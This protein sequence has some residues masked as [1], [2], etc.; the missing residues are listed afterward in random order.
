MCF[1][2]DLHWWLH[3]KM[4][5]NRYPFLWCW[6]LLEQRYVCIFIFHLKSGHPSTKLYNFTFL[7]VRVVTQH[8]KWWE[9]KKTKSCCVNRW[10][11][12]T[13]ALS[14]NKVS[15]FCKAA[16]DAVFVN[17]W[18]FVVGFSLSMFIYFYLQI[19]CN[20]DSIKSLRVTQTI[21]YELYLFSR[22]SMLILNCIEQCWPPSSLL[23][24]STWWW[25]LVQN[26]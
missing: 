17:A 6:L 1:R 23:I 4:K 26:S 12:T 5:I 24:F 14:W 13:T 22:I 25:N 16:N 20:S 8:W 18:S 19:D 7:F 2:G 9:E 15:H 21:S 3:V 10:M 11:N